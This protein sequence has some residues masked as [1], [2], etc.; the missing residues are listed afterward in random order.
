EK[1]LGWA[2]GLLMIGRN[3]GIIVG[4]LIGGT[5]I[6]SFGAGVGFGANAILFVVSAAVVWS[7]QAAVSSASRDGT[8]DSNLT[9]GIR[10]VARDKVLRAMTLAFIPIQF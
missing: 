6:A 7:V 2:N 5:V 8:E 10:F 9:A 4:P 1:R 3:V